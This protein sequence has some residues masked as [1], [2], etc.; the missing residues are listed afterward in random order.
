MRPASGKAAGAAGQ[1]RVGIGYFLFV[2]IT[3]TYSCCANGL[4]LCAKK[5]SCNKLTIAVY[6]NTMNKKTA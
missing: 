4:V 6:N 1:K 2:V 3:H 5:Y